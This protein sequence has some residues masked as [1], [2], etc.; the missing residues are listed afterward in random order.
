MHSLAVGQ[1]WPTKHMD[2]LQ[3]TFTLVWLFFSID[4][5]SS[6]TQ[7]SH[8]HI[9]MTFINTGHWNL[10]VF[11]AL[12]GGMSM[13]YIGTYIKIGKPQL[14]PM[15]KLSSG[16]I[17][18]VAFFYL[19]SWCE[20]TIDYFHTHLHYSALSWNSTPW[21]VNAE[22]FPSHT[23]GVTQTLAV[24]S[25]W[26]WKFIISRGTPNMFMSKVCLALFWLGFGREIC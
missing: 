2:S 20:L 3:T 25:N 26:L 22:M 14:H 15:N 16:S 13:Y 11:G 9:H 10:M 21:I 23:E 4:C 5:E 24:A 8:L 6:W 12:G 1:S 7:S 18:A 19:V 17:S